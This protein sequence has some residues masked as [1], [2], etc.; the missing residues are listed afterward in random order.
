M[1]NVIGNDFLSNGLIKKYDKLIKSFHN[2]DFENIISNFKDYLSEVFPFREKYNI[3]NEKIQKF[4]AIK[5]VY[6]L[7]K[8]NCDINKL[9][10]THILICNKSYPYTYPYRYGLSG[11]KFG[12]FDEV[13]K[14]TDLTQNEINRNIKLCNTYLT[15]NEVL[16]IINELHQDTLNIK[17]I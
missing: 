3:K 8:H 7:F 5:K 16:P 13:Y 6:N 14:T 12:K 10:K 9:L 11:I 1:L 17:N 4:R 15:N 2:N